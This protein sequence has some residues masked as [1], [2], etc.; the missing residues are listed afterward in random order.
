MTT[1]ERVAW[2]VLLMV[3]SYLGCLAPNTWLGLVPGKVK[4]GEVNKLRPIILNNEEVRAVLAGTKRTHRRANPIDLPEGVLRYS[5]GLF[6]LDGGMGVAVRKCPFGYM[7][8]TLWVRETF[9]VESN[10][11]V[12]SAEAYP[13][14]F[15]DGRPVLWKDD[16]NGGRYWQQCHYRATD[17]APE[18]CYDDEDEPVVR[19]RPSIHMPRWARR[20]L[21]HV[22]EVGADKVDG[23]WYWYVRFTVARA[24]GLGGGE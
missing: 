10:R 17:P 14:P 8:D 1:V 11:G 9:A 7:G 3:L 18:L 12:D 23:S 22:D 6:Y 15:N 19:W 5:R 2:L 21:L 4:E 13:P 16:E 20:I 24:A